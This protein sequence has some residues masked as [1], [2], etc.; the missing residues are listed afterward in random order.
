MVLRKFI[1]EAQQGIPSSAIL[2]FSLLLSFF[3]FFPFLWVQ[4]PTVTDM[5]SLHSAMRTFFFTWPR[6]ES[7][8]LRLGD[9]ASPSLFFPWQSLVGTDAALVSQCI[10]KRQKS[11]FEF[12]PHPIK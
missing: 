3:P 5:M 4:F 2:F 8:G 12:F 7:A 10:C 6:S 1:P 11:G 9:G